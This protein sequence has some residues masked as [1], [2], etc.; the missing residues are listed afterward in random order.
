MNFKNV[1][2]RRIR[3]KPRK[4]SMPKSKRRR[5]ERQRKS[6]SSW[7]PRLRQLLDWSVIIGSVLIC[8]M[9][10]PSRL[11]GMQLLGIAPNWLLIWVVAWSVKR[12]AL[13]G[14]FAGIILGLLQDGMTSPEPTHAL[15]L[16]IVGLLT[17]LFQ[18]QRFI[19]EDFIS[20]ALIVFGMSVL[21]ETIFASQMIWMS[22]RHLESIWTYYQKVVLASAILSSLWAPVVY[23]PLNNWWQKVKLAEQP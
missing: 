15:S 19:Q 20:I 23:F 21:S 14:A 5:F 13:Q 7:D 8:L 12:P 11:P 6:L 9:L 10:L 4:S 22:N 2:R 3:R 1:L 16:G 18:K 17:G